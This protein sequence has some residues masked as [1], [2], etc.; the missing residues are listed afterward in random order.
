MAEESA[1]A[2]IEVLVARVR[3]VLARR[4]GRC[5]VGITGP[6]GAG[7]STVASAVV[8][9]MVDPGGGEEPIG[10][11]LVPMDGFHLAGSELARLGSQD[12]KGAP[13]TFDAEGYV[14]LLRRL[15]DREE[16][17]YV[18]EFRREIEEAVAGAIRVDATTDVVITEGN[19]LLLDDGP[20]AGVRPLL[21]EVW[22]LDLDEDVRTGRL[23]ERHVRHGRTPAQAR[24]WAL[25]PDER[26]AERIGATRAS[27][28]LV[29]RAT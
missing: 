23:V 29:L 7:K 22:Y 11:V 17:V 14:H 19:Y 8:A 24:E 9:A 20:W 28:D 10:A 4:P 2:E 26:N 12:R 27:A 15:R 25:G 18:P 1:A 6:P 16:V 5:V 3:S 21:D 13:D